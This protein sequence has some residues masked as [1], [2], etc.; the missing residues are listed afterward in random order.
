VTDSQQAMNRKIKTDNTSGV[1]G[2]SWFQR[3]SKW[4]AQI[5]VN[6][7]LIFLGYFV[8]KHKASTAYRQAAKEYFGEF[9][10]AA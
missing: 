1:K 2:V 7:R 8:S 5:Y 9:M 6:G 10:R 4:R 3:D